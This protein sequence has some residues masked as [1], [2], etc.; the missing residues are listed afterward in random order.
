MKKTAHP[1]TVA[2]AI[3]TALLVGGGP[4]RAQEN[5]I[6]GS[7]A[8][9]ANGPGGKPLGACPLRHTDGADQIPGIGARVTAPREFARGFP[10]PGDAFHP[11]PRC[12]PSPV[13]LMRLHTR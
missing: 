4:A 10:A 6:P 12:D 1:L 11:F 9:D 2:M 13:Y 7:G 8:L 5:P 3:L